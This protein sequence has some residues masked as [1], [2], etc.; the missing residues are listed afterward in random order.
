MKKSKKK[1][2]TIKD[3]MKDVLPVKTITNFKFEYKDFV[4]VLKKNIDKKGIIKNLNITNNEIVKIPKKVVVWKKEKRKEYFFGIE[5]ER[6]LIIENLFIGKCDIFI[7]LLSS[8][9][10]KSIFIRNILVS[11]KKLN[12]VNS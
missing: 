8:S 3:A 6:A 7:E 11:D 4:N 1:I 12:K 9:I 2:K 5:V 10:P